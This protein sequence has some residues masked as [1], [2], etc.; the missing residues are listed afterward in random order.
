METETWWSNVILYLWI[1]QQK[2]DLIG[3]AVEI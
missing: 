1:L 3:K 2:K